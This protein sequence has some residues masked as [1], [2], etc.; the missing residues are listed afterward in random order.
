MPIVNVTWTDSVAYCT[1][2]GGRLPTEAEWEYAAR[3]GTT[4]SR[5]GP[6]DEIAWYLSNSD[7]KTHDVAGRRPNAWNL[8]DM[9]GN[10]WQ[11]VNDR[12]DENYYPASPSVDPQGPDGGVR[13]L[14]GGSWDDEPRRVRVSPRLG[15]EANY[16]RC[17]SLGFR[18]ACGWGVVGS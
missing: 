12:Y 3:A 16:F 14:R 10:V 18:Y 11:W 7:G 4:D 9:L 5:Y 17:G 6:I 1:W 13:V 15:F 8:Y 2:A